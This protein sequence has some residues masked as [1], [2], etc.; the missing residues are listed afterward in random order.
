LLGLALILGGI[1]LAISNQGSIKSSVNPP[2]QS[3]QESES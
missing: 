3:L 2:I 1:Y